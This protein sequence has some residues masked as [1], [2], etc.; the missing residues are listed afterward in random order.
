MASISNG[1]T[2][3][4]SRR[5]TSWNLDDNPFKI[6]YSKGEESVKIAQIL[7]GIKASL[8]KLENLRETTWTRISSIETWLFSFYE[9]EEW[10]VIAVLVYV[11]NII[12][13]RIIKNLFKN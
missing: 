2:C 10:K 1:S 13:K 7:V 11:D 6:W 4:Y 3:I 12:I 8:K 5:F 9:R